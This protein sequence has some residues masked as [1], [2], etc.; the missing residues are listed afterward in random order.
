MQIGTRV[1]DFELPDLDGRVWTLSGLR[2]RT[3]LLYA[4]ASW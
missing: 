3:V 1:P 4:W 2:G